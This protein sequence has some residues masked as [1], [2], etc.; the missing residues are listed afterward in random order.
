MNSR[1]SPG[2]LEIGRIEEIPLR[3]ARR[4]ETATGGIAVFR[5]ADNQVFA[6]ADSCPHANGP[7]SDGIVHDASVTCPLHNWVIDLKS[8]NAMG[9]ESGCTATYP[10][11]IVD[12]CVHIGLC[13]SES[14]DLE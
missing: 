10:V 6:L 14:F 9:G 4:V 12:G 8:G 2:W 1:Q 3:G 11:R 7:L 5:T 13:R